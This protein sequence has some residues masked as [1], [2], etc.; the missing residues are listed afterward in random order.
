MAKDLGEATGPATG[1]ALRAP[2]LPIALLTA[3]SALWFLWTVDGTS[4]PFVAWIPP[5]VCTLLVSHGCLQCARAPGLSRPVRLFWRRIGLVLGLVALGVVSDAGDTLFGPGAPRAYIGPL[6]MGVYIVCILLLVGALLMI[7]VPRRSRNEWLTLGLDAGIFIVGAGLYVWYY[8]SLK[9]A[10]MAETTGAVGSSASVVALSWAVVLITIKLALTGAGPMDRG[11][12]WALGIGVLLASIT[13]GVLAPV[14][15]GR[16]HLAS[17]HLALPVACLLVA[18]GLR[19][20]MA[21]APAGRRRRRHAYSWLPYIAV[22]GVHVLLVISEWSGEG[23]HRAVTIGVILLTGLVVMRQII[24]FCDIGSLLARLDASMAE[25]GRYERRFRALQRYSSDITTIVGPDARITYVSPNIERVL[26]G[27]AEEWVG[28]HYMNRLH[29][30]DVQIMN[31]NVAMMLKDPGGTYT[32]QVRMARTDGTYRCM[33]VHST[34]SYG[35][36]SVGGIVSNLRDI[37]D[38][39]RVQEEL[40]HQA[41]HDALTHLANRALLVERIESALAG[42]GGDG[43]AVALIDLDDFKAINDRL[44]HAVGD[45]LLV[46]I[47]GRL[48]NCVRPGDTVARLGGDEFAVLL[49]DVSADEIDGVLDRIS[50]ALSGIV[51]ALGHDLLVHASIGLAEASGGTDATELMRRADVAMYAVKEGGK[52]GY[53]RYAATMDARADERARLGADLQRGFA[54]G[55]L[56]LVYQP[57]VTL[58]DGGLYGVET[59]IRWRHPERGLVSPVEFVPVAERNGTIVQIGAWVLREA[60]RQMVRWRE[61][62][63]AAA[64]RHLAV[65]VSARQLRDP[66]LVD[67]VADVLAETGMEPADL[68]VEITETAVFDG[69]LA[70]ETVRAVQA[71]GVK[72]AL[73]DFGTGHSSLGLLRTCPVDVLKVDKLFVDEVTGTVGQAAIATS[74]AQIAQALDLTTVAEGVETAAQSRRLY[75]MGYRL[76][77]GYYFAKPLSPEEIDALILRE[78]AHRPV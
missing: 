7:P 24:A 42:T 5:V 55:E 29:P 67:T 78:A 54:R 23:P 4:M 35:D 21:A 50:C 32:F 69:G 70:V 40:V 9:G 49:W 1:P 62:H 16:P 39:V 58:P 65:N 26:G 66:S 72:I 74:I 43:I 17:T 44:G 76:A 20:Q 77:Q 22:G 75:Q 31:D 45:A 41:G 19:R 25:L 59:L 13:G 10:Q 15:D 64:P 3:F 27:P 8:L 71:L 30:D 63:G 57:V 52:S 14:I 47:A 37:T 51:N 61:A 33:E 46:A 12:L 2:I 38:I 68:L 28:T 60:C 18:V 53:R 6:T 34:N 73:D 48:R 56:F 11:A 36:S